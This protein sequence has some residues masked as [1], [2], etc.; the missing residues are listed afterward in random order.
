MF[1]SCRAHHYLSGGLRPP[2]PLTRSLAG[3]P[4]PRSAPVARSLRSLAVVGDRFASL[5]RRRWSASLRSLI[6]L[7]RGGGRFASLA[8]R[9]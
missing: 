6:L 8:H 2:D 7:G 1:E 4:R 3:A 5:A 9:G